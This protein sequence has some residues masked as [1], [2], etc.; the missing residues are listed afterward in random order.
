MCVCVYDL[1]HDDLPSFGDF[2]RIYR[3]SQTPF[4]VSH[5]TAT[6]GGGLVGGGM[7]KQTEK[8]MNNF[9]NIVIVANDCSALIC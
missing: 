1:R 9:L 3:S 8:S 5:T 2:S 4:A 7:G 6:A